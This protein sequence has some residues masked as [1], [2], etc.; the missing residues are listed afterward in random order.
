[1]RLIFW[2]LIIILL[3]LFLVMKSEAFE[4]RQGENCEYVMHWERFFAYTEDLFRSFMRAVEGLRKEGLK[5][6]E[7]IKE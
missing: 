4:Y 1:M 6:L 7:G 2:V 3:F 5:Q